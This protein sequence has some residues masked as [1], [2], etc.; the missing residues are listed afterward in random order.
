MKSKWFITVA[1]LLVAEVFVIW[2]VP[3]GGPEYG[4][5]PLILLAV[6]PLVVAGAIAALW[7]K[8]AVSLAGAVA[9]VAGLAVWTHQVDGASG[10]HIVTFAMFHLPF[11]VLAAAAAALS[12]RGMTVGER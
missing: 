10:V 9:G 4:T 1:L 11:F 5:M 7:K 6:L 12:V 8:H 3:S 2:G